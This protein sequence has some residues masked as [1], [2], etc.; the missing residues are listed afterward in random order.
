MLT[1]LT[2]AAFSVTSTSIWAS[3]VNVF[4]LGFSGSMLIP[5][6]QTR[7]MILAQGAQSLAASMSHSAFNLANAVGAWLGGTVIA[8]GWGYLGPSHVAVLLG[9]LGLSMFVASL[10]VDR[11]KRSRPAPASEPAALSPVHAGV[12][13]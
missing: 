13:R 2:F 10:L 6:V 9:S 3:F 1:I 5:S 4:F 12:S 8:A 11:R 7:L